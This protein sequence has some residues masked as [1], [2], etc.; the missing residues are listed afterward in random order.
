MN[1]SR[2]TQPNK[3]NSA[4]KYREQDLEYKTISPQT[5]KK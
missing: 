1:E 4:E 5:A 3:H 2:T